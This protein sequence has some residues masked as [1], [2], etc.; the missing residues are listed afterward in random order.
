MIK[1]HDTSSGYVAWAG[2]TIADRDAA[3]VDILWRS[4]AVLYVKTANPQ[5]LLVGPSLRMALS[6]CNGTF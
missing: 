4:G 3:P 5:S 2:K 1:G 6:T